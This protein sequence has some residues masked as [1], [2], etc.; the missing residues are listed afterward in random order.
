MKVEAKIKKT[1][2]LIVFDTGYRKDVCEVGTQSVENNQNENGS[3][4]VLNS[5]GVPEK[6]K[7]NFGREGRQK[8]INNNHNNN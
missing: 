4:F 7:K 2:P 8:M 5:S 6:W 3:A 1:L